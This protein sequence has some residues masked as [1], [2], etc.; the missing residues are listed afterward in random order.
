M[1]CIVLPIEANG[2]RYVLLP[3][4]GD[5]L[6]GYTKVETAA[7]L[8]LPLRIKNPGCNLYLKEETA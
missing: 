2:R 7:T 8:E 1:R 4:T 6:P 5:F 3:L